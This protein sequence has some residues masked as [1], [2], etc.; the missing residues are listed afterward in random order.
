MLSNKPEKFYK[1]IG[2]IDINYVDGSNKN[3]YSQ[4][5]NEAIESSPTE[6]FITLGDKAKPNEDHVF[7]C[8]DLLY[9]GFASAQMYCLGFVGWHKELFR[10]IGMF[11]ERYIGGGL[12]HPDMLIRMKEAN[13]AYYESLEVPYD[14]A[15]GSW[16]KSGQQESHFYNKWISSSYEKRLLPEEKTCYS[17]GEGDS[18]IKFKPYKESIILT[19]NLELYNREFIYEK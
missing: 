12:E 9:S 4:L 6:H 18:Q 1:K 16:S 8:L 15:N 5:I 19:G 11:D 3:S 14:S 7:K 17:L 2:S 10:R 13:I